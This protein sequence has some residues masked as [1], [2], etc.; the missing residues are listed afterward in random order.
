MNMLLKIKGEKVS[1][2]LLIILPSLLLLMTSCV[3]ENF[4]TPECPEEDDSVY[5]LRIM[6]DN[7]NITTRAAIHDKTEDGTKD[8]NFINISGKD[9]SVLIFDAS[10]NYILTLSPD[11]FI[12]NS[13]GN[14]IDDNFTKY[15]MVG[16]VD[17]ETAKNK[18]SDGEF[19]VMVLANWKS[20]Q[21]TASYPD[22]NQNSKIADIITDEKYKFSFIEGWGPSI[23]GKK[24]IPMF[25]M[26]TTK[27]G[28]PQPDKK[29][30]ESHLLVEVPMLRALA[31]IEIEDNVSLNNNKIQLENAWLSHRN[32][33]GLFIPNIVENPDWGTEKKQVS[34]ATLLK[35]GTTPVK[36]EVK[37]LKVN[38]DLWA[39]IPEMNLPGEL[40]M[41]ER[42]FVRLNVK[43][44]NSNKNYEYS[45]HFCGYENGA[46]DT[47]TKFDQILRNH[48]YRFTIDNITET[49]LN[50]KVGICPW[51]EEKIEI[52]SF[53]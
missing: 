39:Y 32:A 44:T 52:P 1:R 19:K 15:E 29:T 10:D 20:Y 46:P 14:V 7:G 45:L 36:N 35:D 13:S 21:S 38:N 11:K 3:F 5:L 18:L 34:K 16:V 12:L 49:E 6:V 31:K 40:F 8:E 43:E 9:F 42:P 51:E 2:F 41:E 27:D 4:D 23:N 48:I 30:G 37:F 25:G 53:Q 17:K 28:F 24:C 26:A 33:E 47:K 22:M 50:L